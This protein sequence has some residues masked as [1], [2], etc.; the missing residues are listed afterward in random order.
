MASSSISNFRDLFG[1][2]IRMGRVGTDFGLS[3]DFILA[4]SAMTKETG[5]AGKVGGSGIVRFINRVLTKG[6]RLF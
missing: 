1:T 3:P 5:F 4:I 6:I 2:A